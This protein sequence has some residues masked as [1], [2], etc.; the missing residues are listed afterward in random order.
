M[1]MPMR[2]TGGVPALRG[3]AVAFI[4]MNVVLATAPA[5]AASPRGPNESTATGYTAHAPIL[6]IGDAN[7]TPE[8]GVVG[9]SGTSGAPY[10]IEG[11][12]ISAASTDGLA[13]YNTTAHVL[14]RHVYIHGGWD[15]AT[16]WG[17]N[18]IFLW[19]AVNV[20]IDNSTF[21]DNVAGVL[22]E[23]AVGV[24]VDACLFT[25]NP[26]GG[27][28]VYGNQVVVGN[29]TFHGNGLGFRGGGDGVL[30]QDNEFYLNDPGG[31]LLDSGSGVT[32]RENDFADGLHEF[33]E[34][35]G[36]TNVRLYHNN[37][38]DEVPPYTSPNATLYFDDGYP[39]GGNYWSMYSGYDNCT[40]PAQN[41][42]TGG[43]G[44]GDTPFPAWVGLQV[45]HYPLMHPFGTHT[46]PPEVSLE[47][48]PA[49]L[50][51]SDILVSNASRSADPDGPA[52]ALR[53]RWR[54]GDGSSHDP[55]L[56]SWDTPWSSS[57]TSVHTYERPGTYTVSLEVIDVYGWTNET[58]VSVVVAPRPFDWTPWLPWIVVSIAIVTLVGTMV[59]WQRR[60]EKKHP[61]WTQ[62]RRPHS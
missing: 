33:L 60:W 9:G 31:M 13:I 26:F 12:N 14:V 23:G 39:T 8:N 46:R 48:S 18:G 2:R 61:D 37:I 56:G 40:G 44:I 36:A 54:W 58:S 6:I 27:A 51:P 35:V 59:W 43:D 21:D 41:V 25:A 57:P 47:V 42:C 10:L 45:D 17:H 32:V 4:L 30:V 16:D 34:Y 49:R 38:L 15:A 7:F 19:N 29:S 52:A 50:Y 62:G 5:G 3:A 28:I 55:S 24:T 11:W 20:R 22:T 1:D 53:F